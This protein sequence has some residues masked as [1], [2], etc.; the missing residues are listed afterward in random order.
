MMTAGSSSIHH[1][2]IARGSPGILAAPGTYL[3]IVNA[4]FPLTVRIDGMPETK[5]LPGQGIHTPEEFSRV[6]FHTPGNIAA[7]IDVWCGY[8]EFIDRRVNQYEA[9]T[10]L[11]P[12]PREKIEA[13]ETVDFSGEAP[14]LGYYRRRNITISN[15]DPAISLW[16]YKGE[17]RGGVVRPGETICLSETGRISVKNTATAAVAV[18]IGEYWWLV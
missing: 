5:L 2:A 11:V 7:E 18:A 14:S 16:I 17:V 4:G 10:E 9:P 13:N 3:Q 6:V 12:W 1:V 15:L 8:S